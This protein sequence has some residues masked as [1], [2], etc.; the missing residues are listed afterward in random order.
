MS[1]ED[2]SSTGGS[3]EFVGV[4]VD[5]RSR[6]IAESNKSAPNMASSIY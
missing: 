6:E 2:Q 5:G 3:M 4:F 1:K